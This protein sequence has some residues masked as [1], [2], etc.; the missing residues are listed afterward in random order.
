MTIDNPTTTVQITIP[1]TAPS[2]LL[3]RVQAMARDLAEN[4][5][6]TVE[7]AEIRTCQKCGCT[8]DQG[9]MFGCSWVSESEDLC[10]SCAPAPSSTTK[11]LIR[12]LVAYSLDTDH[13]STTVSHD[14]D[15]HLNLQ[16]CIENRSGFYIPTDELTNALAALSQACLSAVD[17]EALLQLQAQLESTSTFYIPVDELEAALHD[18]HTRG[19]SVISDL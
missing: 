10:T 11:G 19:W 5:G 6:I 2:D 9:C 8:D 14:E 18:L 12:R 4:S 13:G 1:K 16:E 17:E 7:L 15:F 3:E